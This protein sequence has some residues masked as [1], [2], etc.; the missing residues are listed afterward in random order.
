CARRSVGRIACWGDD[1]YGELGD[2]GTMKRAFALDVL[3]TS[4]STLINVDA[5]T[6]GHDHARARI[7]T[8]VFCWGRND[9]GQLGDGST[10][11]RPFPV[12]SG[13]SGVGD[14]IA[15]AFFTCA[16]ISDSLHCW[17]KNDSGQIGDGTTMN[18][19]NP[20][21]VLATAQPP[22]AL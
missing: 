8:N 12:Q 20:V 21:Q 13:V 18:R 3:A 16:R 10:M 22:T 14:V 17:G 6:A 5:V 2:N 15:G 1:G 9:T 4:S 19:P 7:G 11:N